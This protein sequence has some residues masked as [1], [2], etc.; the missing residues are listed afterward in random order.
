MHIHYFTSSI[1][2]VVIVIVGMCLLS[3][4]RLETDDLVA[5]SQFMHKDMLW[6][7]MLMNLAT[8]SFRFRLNF[9]QTSQMYAN[10]DQMLIICCMS[11]TRPVKPWGSNAD[12][13][14]HLQGHIRTFP[15]H[16]LYISYT[17]PSM[18]ILSR[19][20]RYHFCCSP[21][22][23]LFNVVWWLVWGGTIV[24]IFSKIILHRCKWFG[25]QFFWVIFLS[26]L[27]QILF[28]NNIDPK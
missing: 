28:M 24:S 12:G 8:L 19:P 22:T 20:V 3:W 2:I 15:P 14:S 21:P 25:V 10:V 23:F 17:T 16:V 11:T 4:F 27:T 7:T 26:F 13:A 9:R 6:S 5:R 18:T 1:I